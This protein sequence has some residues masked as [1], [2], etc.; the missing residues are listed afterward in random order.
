MDEKFN[1]IFDIDDKFTESLILF[2]KNSQK[3]N[4]LNNI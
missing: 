2:A 4:Y 1:D 3:K